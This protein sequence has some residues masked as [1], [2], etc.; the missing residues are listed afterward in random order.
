MNPSHKSSDVIQSTKLWLR[1]IIVA[2][3]FCPFAKKEL[4]RQTIHFCVTQHSTLADSLELL[5]DQFQYLDQ[6][7]DVETTLIIFAQSFN[8]FDDYLELVEYANGMLE[9]G[10]YNGIFQLA[11]FHPDYC[12]AGEPTSDPANYTNRSPY[13]IIHILREQSLSRVL[14]QYPNPESIPDNNIAKTR[15]LGAQDLANRLELTRLG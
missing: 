1:D 6:H 7:N 8:D 15:E 14:K 3:N 11:T 12:F 10:G 13:P 4:E 9:Q 2:L 5:L